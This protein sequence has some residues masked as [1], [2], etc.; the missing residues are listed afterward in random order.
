MEKEE[1][2]KNEK[3]EKFEQKQKEEN[4]RKDLLEQYKPKCKCRPPQKCINC[5]DYV[6]REFKHESFDNFILD[7]Q[8][9]NK[10]NLTT[11]ALEQSYK[12]QK[13]STG[14]NKAPPSIVLSR[15]VYRHVDYVSFMN[16]KEL[17]KF[18]GFW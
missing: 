7:L 8:K 18:I 6:T 15:Q 1:K 2:E 5:P 13:K 9:K 3:Q 12:T 17:G 4:A 16:H 14:Q 10:L 11:F